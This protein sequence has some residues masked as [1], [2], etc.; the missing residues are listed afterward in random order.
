MKKTIT[1][2]NPVLINGEQTAEL[3][4]DANDITAGLFA[5]ADVRRKMAAGI[6]NVSISP[7]AEF[8]Y[9]LHL[10]IGFAAIIAANPGIDFADLERIHGADV[11]KVMDI[12]RNFI[13][14]SENQVLETSD[15][16]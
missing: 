14:K 3:T 5:E 7:A 8:D 11:L 15:E 13:L 12:G 16:Q 4:Y 1:L 6:R 10:Y 9:G 2:Q